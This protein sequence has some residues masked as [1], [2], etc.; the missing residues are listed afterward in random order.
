M[1]TYTNPVY[2]GTFADP[3]VLRHEDRYYAFGTGPSAE[4]RPFPTLVSDDFVHWSPLGGALIPAN[5]LEE[6]DYWAPEVAY[7]DGTFFMVYSVGGE[8]HVGHQL[9]VATSERPEGPYRDVGYP[10]LDP[11]AAPFAI[12]AHPYQDAGGHWHLYYARD[13]L[14]SPR[15]GTSLV[16][17]PWD[18]PFRLPTEFH[19]VAR[20]SH[21]WQLYQRRR[22][23]PQ[24]GTELYEWHTLEGPFVVPHDGR[25][26]LLYSGGNFGN[27]SYG[28]DY[29]VA[30]EVYGEYRDNNEGAGARVLRTVPGHVIGPGHNSVVKGPNDE[31]WMIYHA[32]DL[33]GH[34]RH[35]CLDPLRW[36][37]EGPRCAPTWTEQRVP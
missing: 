35:L 4:G 1:P 12:D 32:W 25:L 15:P 26:F 21:D 14:D 10:L 28:V 31:D 29:L 9:R 3:F 33:E 13:L 23:M 34:G 30:D 16:V 19:V 22:R 24:Y 18:D 8:D 20:A 27:E 5:G 7:R 37:D 17:A 36:T 6:G 11:A 2:P